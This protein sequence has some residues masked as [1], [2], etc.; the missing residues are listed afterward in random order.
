[1][2]SNPNL[3]EIGTVIRVSNLL[4]NNLAIRKFFELDFIMTN[5]PVPEKS[6]ELCRVI[7]ETD[8]EF[9]IDELLGKYIAEE[10]RIIIY[11][12]AIRQISNILKVTE[13]QITY[14]VE[15][16]EHAHAA[17]Y[18]GIPSELIVDK[19]NNYLVNQ[20]TLLGTISPEIHE[21]LAQLITWQV[22]QGEMENETNAEFKEW[23]VDTL[24]VFDILESKQPPCYH[25]TGL[26]TIETKR[27]LSAYAHLKSL[28][29]E[30]IWL[31]GL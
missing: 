29:N 13:S 24:K 12:E 6:E 4:R 20:K 22:L 5:F 3:E 16:H 27:V 10:N 31:K 15:L 26:K 23:Y 21:R 11:S 18:Q 9:P 30:Q 28:N 8:D 2:N 17:V 1:M 14:I 7:N 25:I 19:Q